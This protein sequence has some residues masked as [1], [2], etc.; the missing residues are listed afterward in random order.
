[1]TRFFT[2]RFGHLIYRTGKIGRVF[3][4]IVLAMVLL[5]PSASREGRAAEGEIEI[6]VTSGAKIPNRATAHK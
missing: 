2:C 5:L 1:M 6:G 4:A 3:V